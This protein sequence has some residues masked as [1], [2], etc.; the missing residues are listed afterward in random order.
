MSNDIGYLI[1]EAMH[2]LKAF[3]LS[4]ETL[5]PYGIR[6]FQSILRFYSDR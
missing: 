5:K 3:G 2:Q 6:A 4:E 1:Q